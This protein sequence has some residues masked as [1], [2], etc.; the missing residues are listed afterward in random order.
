MDLS[1]YEKAKEKVYYRKLGKVLNV[2]GLTIESAGPDAR[3]ADICYIHP[4]GDEGPGIM[5]EVVGF[6]DGRTLLMPYENTEGIGIGNL[7][8]NTGE[9]L[10]VAVGDFLLGR[11]LDGLGRPAAGDVRIPPDAVTYSVEA[12]PP[13]PMSRAII[14]TPLPLGVKAVDGLIT[15]GAGQRIGIFAGSGVGKSTLM[16][17]FARNTKAEINVI[18]LIGERGR[19]VREFIER[20]LGEE[21]MRRSVVVVATSDK[22]ALERNKAAKTATAIA[23]YFR[24]QGRDVLLMLESLTRFCMAQRE[25]GLATG[26]PPVTRGYPPSVYSELPKLLERAGRAA[27]GSIT[28]LYTVL[29]DGDDFNEP[30]TDTARSILD[31]HIMLN[32][33]LAHRNHYPAV[34]ILQSISRCMSQVASKEHK[35][36][37]GKLKNVLATYNEA[38]DLINIGAYKKGSNPNIDYAVEKINATNEFLMQDVE[39]KY[40]FEETVAM[41]EE[42]YKG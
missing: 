13:D 16:G 33:K 12:P 3:L 2:V 1:K 40:T 31:G 22:P 25:I 26:E 35:K 34:D 30:I 7:V 6:K 10:R 11:T 19:E 20:D 39:S 21:G 32:R 37:A 41:L 28:G 5:A 42:L 14:D 18:A 17:M 36:A 4:E 38:E 27:S 23:E 9:S 8:E 15:V 24:D 29:V